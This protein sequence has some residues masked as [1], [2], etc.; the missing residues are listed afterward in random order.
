MRGR[1]FSFTLLE[2]SKLSKAYAR[3]YVL[4]P[5]DFDINKRISMS[6]Q[7]ATV[8]DATDLWQILDLERQ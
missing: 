8:A 2:Q 7:D 5:P 6:L 4:N 3:K 1:Y